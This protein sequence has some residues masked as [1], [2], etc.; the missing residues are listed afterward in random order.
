MWFNRGVHWRT[1]RDSNPELFQL[2]LERAE[3]VYPEVVDVYRDTPPTIECVFGTRVTSLTLQLV[4]AEAVNLYG[5]G[6]CTLLALAMH[7]LS[8]AP[9]VLFTRDQT[10]TQWKGHAAV[11]IREDAYLD[12]TGVRTAESIRNEYRLNSNPEEVT[13]DQFCSR[14]ASGEH[15]SDPMRFVDRLEQLITVDFAGFLLK[16]AGVCLYTKPLMV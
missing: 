12:I 3:E 4:D 13:R 6:Y 15:E 9:L 11:K 5:W 8:D 1:Y 10:E 16:N 14:V 2:A 7:D